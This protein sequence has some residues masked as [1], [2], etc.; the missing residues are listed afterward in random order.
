MHNISL[1]N[2]AFSSSS[3]EAAADKR[4]V[5]YH[6]ALLSQ[7]D[8]GCYNLLDD[9]PLC[10]V[11]RGGFAGQTLGQLDKSNFLIKI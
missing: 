7:G 11:A 10:R 8:R 1:T 3:S 6:W 4:A 9:D 5:Q 2:S